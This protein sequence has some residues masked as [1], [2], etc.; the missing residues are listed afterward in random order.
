[1]QVD[2]SPHRQERRLVLNRHLTA[3]D[4]VAAQ[5]VFDFF[6]GQVSFFS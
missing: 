1:M 4:V 2:K 5:A 6:G 3:F